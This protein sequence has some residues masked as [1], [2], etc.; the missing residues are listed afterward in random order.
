MCA[1]RREKQIRA[2]CAPSRPAI[3]SK[4]EDM[5]PAVGKATGLA[6]VCRWDRRQPYPRLGCPCQW[7]CGLARGSSRP[8]VSTRFPV[9][10]GEEIARVLRR[11]GFVLAG[12]KGSHQK[13]R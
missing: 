2:T 10:H 7:P 6:L 11:H 9:R 13:W 12:K 3:D 8:T 1:T 4:S 5:A